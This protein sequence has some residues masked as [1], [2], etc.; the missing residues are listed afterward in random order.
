MARPLSQIVAVLLLSATIV[1]GA[2]ALHVL[3][4]A[5]APAPVAGCHH[6]PAPSNPAPADYRCC[7][8]GH[9][10]AL[11]NRIF[12]PRPVLQAVARAR[13]IHAV[14]VASF[15]SA[16]PTAFQSSGR[17]PSVSILRI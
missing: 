16:F 2:G 14:A 7:A 12:S 6:G 13:A 5:A 4:V 9:R 15:S 17:P 11:L 8:S 10:T 1:A 3:S